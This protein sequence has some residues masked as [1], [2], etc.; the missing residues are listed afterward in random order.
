MKEIKPSGYWTKERCQEEALK[1]I[2]RKE[3]GENSGSA[4]KKAC[5]NKWID[6]ICIHMKI[7]GSLKTRCIYAYEFPDNTVYVGLT[8]NLEERELYRKR[9]SSDGVTKHIK[10]TNLTPIRKQLTD[11]IP[12]DI[13]KIKEGEYVEEYK[14]NGWIILNISKTGSI[15]G[16]TIKWTK[17]KCI[18]EAQKYNTRTAFS[19]G[20]NSCYGVVRKQGWL[21]DICKHMKSIIRPNNYWNIKKNCIKSTEKYTFASDWRKYENSAYNGARRNGWLNDCTIYLSKKDRKKWTIET[22]IENARNYTIYSDWMKS[23]KKCICCGKKIW[24]A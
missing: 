10:E 5:I 13:A 24:L 18:L 1:Y 19:K 3:F 22:C 7:F 14:N 16:T 8:Y 20:S 15:G 23:E 11:Y 4:Y 2:S 17:E 12:V 9:K 21:D 6:E